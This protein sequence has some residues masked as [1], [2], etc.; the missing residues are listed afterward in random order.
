MHSVPRENIMIRRFVVNNGI[1]DKMLS[2]K[3]IT[4]IIIIKA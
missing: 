3:F 2:F 1:I 4:C